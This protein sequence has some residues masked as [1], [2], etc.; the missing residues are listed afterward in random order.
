[1]HSLW[2][3]WS[4]PFERARLATFA[5]SGSYLGS[6]AALSLG[7]FIGSYWNWQAIFYIFGYY[8]M[9]ITLH[10][11]A[12]HMYPMY[13]A[14]L[15]IIGFILSTFMVT[16]PHCIAM[17]WLITEGSNVIVTMW[18]AIGAYVIQRMLRRPNNV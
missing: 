3:K 14:P 7:G 9:W 6:V 10:Y 1:M 17:R 4:P 11:L 13:C 8:L 16:T 2:S 12:V 5:L 15:T 18:L